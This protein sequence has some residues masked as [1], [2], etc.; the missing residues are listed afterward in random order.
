MSPPQPVDELAVGTGL[1]VGVGDELVAAGV[2][3]AA[4]SKALPAV[5][6]EM[7][8]GQDEHQPNGEGRGCSAETPQ[9]FNEVGQIG[10]RASGQDWLGCGPSRPRVSNAAR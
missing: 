6:A 4:G 8:E 2:L 1:V 10:E 5:V 7:S 3:D 9:R